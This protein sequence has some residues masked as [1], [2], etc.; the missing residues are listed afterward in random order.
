MNE[1][2]IRLDSA[3]ADFERVTEIRT[4]SALVRALGMIRDRELK[5]RGSECDVG[6]IEEATSELLV[7]NGEDPEEVR[8]YAKRRAEDNLLKLRAAF[9]DRVAVGRRSVARRVLPAVAAVA[10]L[11]VAAVLTC[12]ALGLD[13]FTMTADFFSSLTNKQVYR[14]GEGSVEI[15]KTDDAERFGALSAALDAYPVDGA[16]CSPLFDDP[17]LVEYVDSVDY[18]T[19]R[20]IRVVMKAGAVR[21][22]EITYPSPAE[23]LP[24]ANRRIGG[25]D[26]CVSS[27]DGI[28]QA[29]WISDG[30]LYVL[31]A[32]SENE[33]VSAIGSLK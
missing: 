28:F 7:L 32:D 21:E 13:V 1:R 31:T 27:Y 15:V 5:K 11:L 16:L 26:A 33:L 8:S 22:Y 10:A 25:I 14:D 6:L 18:G 12:Y 3:I 4:D 30:A 19:H 2:I 23:S 29:E 20:Q 9:S 17:E 24:S